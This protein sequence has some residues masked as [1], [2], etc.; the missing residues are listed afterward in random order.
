[1][2][3]I[4]RCFLHLWWYLFLG[5]KWRNGWLTESRFFNF[6]SQ[7]PFPGA[8]CMHTQHPGK[9]HSLPFKEEKIFS[10]RQLAS[11]VF[12][13]RYQHSSSQR[14]RRKVSQFGDFQSLI[15]CSMLSAW[16]VMTISSCLTWLIFLQ[17]LSKKCLWGDVKKGRKE[18]QGT[19]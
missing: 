8:L 6:P 7:I 4:A 15:A 18:R 16:P 12:F 10:S 1:M 11:T 13:G 17:W 3:C 9:P 14:G 5:C 2:Q 19:L